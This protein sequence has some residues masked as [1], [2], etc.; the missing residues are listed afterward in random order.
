[1]V[2]FEFFSVVAY[3]I[4]G[5][6]AWKVHS[7]IQGRKDRGEVEAVDPDEEAATRQKARDLW[8]RQY[9]MEGL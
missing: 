9:H 3:G 8:H 4:H 7:V 5:I 1:M 6:M 2:V